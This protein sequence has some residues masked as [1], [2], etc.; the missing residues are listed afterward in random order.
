V[1][2][3]RRALGAD[4]R[5]AGV[6]AAAGAVTMEPHLQCAARIHSAY[7]ATTEHFGYESPG[8]V[9]GETLHETVGRAGYSGVVVAQEI[10]IGS[11]SAES[12]IDLMLSADADCANLMQPLATQIGVGHSGAGTGM[13]AH[14]W[15]L[16]LGY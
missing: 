13:F 7:M 15:T 1:L 3:D 9:L 16:V 8:G 5:T 6:F 12:L 4:C 11:A 10:G 2:N 14:S